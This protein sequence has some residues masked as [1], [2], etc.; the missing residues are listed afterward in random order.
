MNEGVGPLEPLPAAV[1]AFI[2]SRISSLLQLE[3]LLLV[4]EGGARVRSAEQLA[5][6]MYVP[7][8]V[9][10]EWLDEFA[11][12][13]LCERTADGYRTADHEPAFRLL[14]AVADCYVRRRISL[15]R[16]I[17]SPPPTDARSSL[18]E[19]FRLRKDR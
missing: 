2:T 7:S 8:G 3:A 11:T 12:T 17:F 14:S 1:V 6:E 16:L 10:T 13:G 4:F 19:A 5:A 18:A 9:L 15:S